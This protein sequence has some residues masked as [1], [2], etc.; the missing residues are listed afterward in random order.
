VVLDDADLGHAVN[1][2]VFTR[3]ADRGVRFAQRAEAG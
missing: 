1:A 3:D 2:V